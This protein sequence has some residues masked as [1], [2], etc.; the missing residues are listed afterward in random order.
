MLH[1]THGYFMDRILRSWMEYLSMEIGTSS[2]SYS[3]H[4]M[5]KNPSMGC[6]ISMDVSK[7]HE[8]VE[9]SWHFNGFATTSSTLLTT[10]STPPATATLIIIH[11]IIALASD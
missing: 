11:H 6:I 7:I 10:S 1:S 3:T 2:W 9:Y 5:G 4:L 8:Y